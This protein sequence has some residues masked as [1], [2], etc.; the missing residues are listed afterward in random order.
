MRRLQANLA[1]GAATFGIMFYFLLKYRQLQKRKRATKWIA[2]LLPL[3]S[4][5]VVIGASG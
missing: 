5:I 1:V 2:K 3:G 4:K